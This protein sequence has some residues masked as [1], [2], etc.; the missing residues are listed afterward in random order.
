MEVLAPEA[1]LTLLGTVLSLTDVTNTEIK[2]RISAAWRLFWSMKALLLN[3]NV[4]I[5]RRLRLFDATVGSCV[6]WCCESWSPRV[7]EL[8]QLEVARRSMLRKLV[9]ARRAPTEDWIDWIQRATHKALHWSA[10]AGVREWGHFDFERKWIWAGHV[11]RSSA[12]TWLY[13]VTSWRDSAWQRL[14]DDIGMQR[15]TRPSTGRWMKWEDPIRRYCSAQGLKAW[16]ELAADR[17]Q[18]TEHTERF[19]RWSVH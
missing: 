3:Q 14:S 10:R 19:R 15:V 8:R 12:Q 13:K 9:G 6:T 16:E 18:W 17:E 5:T 11:A 2:N 1:N 7:G 4:T